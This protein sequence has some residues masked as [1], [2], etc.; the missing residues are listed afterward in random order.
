MWQRSLNKRYKTNLKFKKEKYFC[1]ETDMIELI[2]IFKNIYNPKEMEERNFSNKFM[3]EEVEIKQQL[4][5][6]EITLILLR[7]E[8]TKILLSCMKC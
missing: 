4:P 6:S 1:R 3:E 7:N 5:E 2:N 8:H